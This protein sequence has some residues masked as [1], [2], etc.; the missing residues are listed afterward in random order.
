MSM[1]VV[2]LSK[3]NMSLSVRDKGL[4][5]PQDCLKIQDF[6]IA[7]L[8]RLSYLGCKV[9]FIFKFKRLKKNIV[10]SSLA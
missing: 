4:I 9:L 10:D 1:G 5:L 6:L 3:Q 2:E 7:S 8:L